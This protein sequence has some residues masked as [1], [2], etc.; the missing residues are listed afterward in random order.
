[1]SVA[2]KPTACDRLLAINELEA[3][4]CARGESHNSLKGSLKGY[5]YRVKDLLEYESTRS[6]FVKCLQEKE[7]KAMEKKLEES[8]N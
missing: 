1:M 5:L 3:G 7:R 4:K 6:L 2:R 8:L